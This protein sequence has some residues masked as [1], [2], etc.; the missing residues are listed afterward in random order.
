MHSKN[1]KA[2]M[3]TIIANA[4]T[5]VENSVNTTNKYAG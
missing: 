4:R 3:P 5:F 2:I 1:K